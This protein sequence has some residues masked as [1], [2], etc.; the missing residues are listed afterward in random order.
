M[1]I[2][3]SPSLSPVQRLTP[4]AASSSGR[5]LPVLGTDPAAGKEEGQS[6]RGHGGARVAF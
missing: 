5:D 2:L 1:K 3:G 6:G 4:S